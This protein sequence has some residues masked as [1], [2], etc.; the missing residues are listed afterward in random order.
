MTLARRTGERWTRGA[1]AASGLTQAGQ[2]KAQAS[3]RQRLTQL[4]LA[5]GNAL[6]AARGLRFDLV[7]SRQRLQQG[8]SLGDLGHFRR[9]RKVFERGREKGMRH[10]GTPGRLIE[11]RQP[12]RGLQAETARAPI[13]C[14]RDGGAI[15][16]FGEPA[17]HSGG[18]MGDAGLGRIGCCL[19]VVEERRRV[20]PHRWQLASRVAADP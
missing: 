11:L 7:S 2:V 6:F 9:R 10:G 5:Y 15:G 20:R 17:S 18:A 4:Q 8:R 14:D 16:V 1:G 13:S 12:E 19:E 3:R